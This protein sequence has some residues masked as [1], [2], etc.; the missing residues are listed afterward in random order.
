MVIPVEQST[1]RCFQK[2]L[3]VILCTALVLFAHQ[4]MNHRSVHPQK[5]N[6]Y[7]YFLVLGYVMANNIFVYIYWFMKFQK[8]AGHNH[9][10]NVNIVALLYEFH[11]NN[12]CN[13]HSSTVRTQLN[14]MWHVT[15]SFG[16][17]RV[18]ATHNTT[19]HTITPHNHAHT[20]TNKTAY[21]T[22]KQC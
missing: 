15:N 2:H 16:L 18:Y 10:S 7:W 3:K 21:I 5:N 4:T 20:H 8:R 6:V 1:I 19:R 9:Y 13:V 14:R 22:C 17:S 12:M 11:T